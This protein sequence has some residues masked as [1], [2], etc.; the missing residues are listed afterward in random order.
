ML[1]H[2]PPTSMKANRCWHHCASS[3]ST[4]TDTTGRTDGVTIVAVCREDPDAPARGVPTDPSL[5]RRVGKGAVPRRQNPLAHPAKPPLPG[6]NA[7]IVD[8]P[9]RALA[10]K[11]QGVAA[12][13]AGRSLTE[14][15][16]KKC[17]GEDVTA[18][19]DHQHRCP[20]SRQGCL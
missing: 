8:L 16:K 5:A 9:T 13:E 4:A 3:K 2:E 7:F 1:P 12:G 15:F 14:E 20:S 11:Q 17:P 6:S 18:R 19:S 10:L